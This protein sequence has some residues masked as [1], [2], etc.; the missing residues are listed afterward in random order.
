VSGSSTGDGR[1]GDIGAAD[2]TAGGD[3]A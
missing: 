2:G 3:N 1:V